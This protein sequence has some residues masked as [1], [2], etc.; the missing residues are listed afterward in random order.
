M[1]ENIEN[2]AK[3]EKITSDYWRWE[4][5]ENGKRRSTGNE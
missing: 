1:K 2:K 3:K 4:K 5:F